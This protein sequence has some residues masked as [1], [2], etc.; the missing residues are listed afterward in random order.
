V[1]AAGLWRAGA[2]AGGGFGGVIARSPGA[3]YRQLFFD[4]FAGALGAS[5]FFAARQHDGFKVVLAAAAGVFKNRHGASIL[6]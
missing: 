1:A 5:N 4:G 6:W 3:E 2:A